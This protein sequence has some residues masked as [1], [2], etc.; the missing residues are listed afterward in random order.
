MS[1]ERR[2]R[3]KGRKKRRRKR[4]RKK[5]EEEEKTKQKRKRKK[6]KKFKVSHLLSD[7][8]GFELTS[9]PLKFILL[10]IPVIF[11]SAFQKLL[12]F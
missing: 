1:K 5:K 10:H 9:L 7:G 12:A 2:K 6:N 3:E 4:K 11:F 8:V